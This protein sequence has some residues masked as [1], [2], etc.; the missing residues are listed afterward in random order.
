MVSDASHLGWP[1]VGAVCSAGV[2]VVRRDRDGDRRGFLPAR[3]SQ[4]LAWLQKICYPLLSLIDFRAGDW[5]LDGDGDRGR[6][7]CDV[8]AAEC[9]G[10]GASRHEL[11]GEPLRAGQWRLRRKVEA[12]ALA[13]A[14]EL[15]RQFALHEPPALLA[16]PAAEK[17]P[18]DSLQ[19]CHSPDPQR[20][21]VQRVRCRLNAGRSRA[22]SRHFSL[23]RSKCHNYGEISHSRTKR[24][25]HLSVSIRV[26][27]LYYL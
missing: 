25:I 24:P 26:H 2:V 14:L 6:R 17:I 13:V 23:Y 9:R 27:E 11:P 22:E 4:P 18:P 5:H 19:R 3:S 15:P 8:G 12:P 10:Y 20:S 1:Y 16:V 7:W 21:R